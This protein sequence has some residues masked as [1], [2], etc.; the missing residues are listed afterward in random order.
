MLESFLLGLGRL[1]GITALVSNTEWRTA[2]RH[3]PGRIRPLQAPSGLTDHTLSGCSQDVNGVS[4]TLSFTPEPQ[5]DFHRA[6]EPPG[7]HCSG[8]FWRGGNCFFF[9]FFRVLA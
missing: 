2:M 1:E 7:P 8:T 6:M 5:G 4:V 3:E 9:F